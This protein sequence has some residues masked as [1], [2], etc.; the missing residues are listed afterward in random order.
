MN[1]IFSGKTVILKP[2]LFLAFFSCLTLLHAQSGEWTLHS[3]SNGVS[4]SYK[5]EVC[6]GNNTLF[7]KFENTA[8]AE[9]NVHFTLVVES[10][11]LNIPL[12]PR[13]VHLKGNESQSGDCDADPVLKAEI[14]TITNLSLRVILNVN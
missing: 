6:E 12:P 7:L 3:S 1:T 2:V 9:K 10:P 14:N 8:S 13:F 4:F 5:T 11:G